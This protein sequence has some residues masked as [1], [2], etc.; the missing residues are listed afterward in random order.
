MMTAQIAAA[1]GSQRPAGIFIFFAIAKA[2]A[3]HA[4][5]PLVPGQLH[6]SFRV[7]DADQFGRFRAVADIIVVPVQ[8]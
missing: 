1:V 8:K 3:K 2:S 6:K 5:H 7:G 4:R